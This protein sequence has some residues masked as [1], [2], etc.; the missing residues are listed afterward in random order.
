M[1]TPT[2]TTTPMRPGAQGATWEL[3]SGRQALLIDHSLD[4]QVQYSKK[5][6]KS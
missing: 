5:A 3:S 1:A 6:E 4:I 2:A